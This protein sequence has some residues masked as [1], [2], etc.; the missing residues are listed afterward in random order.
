MGQIIVKIVTENVQSVTELRKLVPVNVVAAAHKLGVVC[1][2]MYRH[3][4]ID[5]GGFNPLGPQTHR[6]VHSPREFG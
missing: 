5:G 1:Q 3:P 2:Y 4:A 6:Q